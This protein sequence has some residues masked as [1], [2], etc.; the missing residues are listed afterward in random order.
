MEVVVDAALRV[1]GSTRERAAQEHGEMGEVD[2]DH[3]IHCTSR[4]FVR[5]NVELV[6]NAAALRYHTW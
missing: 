5:L 4:P 6:Q 2:P 1:S 3:W